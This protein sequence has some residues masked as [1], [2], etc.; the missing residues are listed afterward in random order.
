MSVVV[1]WSWTSRLHDARPRWTSASMKPSVRVGHTRRASS[2]ANWVYWPTSN[3]PGLPAPGG[4]DV[5]QYTQ[6]AALLARL[7][8]PTLTLG[9]M[10]ALVQRGRASWSRLVQL[11]ETTTDIPDG[12]QPPLAPSKL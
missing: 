4:F 7:V 9:F 12:A 1:S 11:Q 5:G 8:W 3:P 6:F 10:L 2:A